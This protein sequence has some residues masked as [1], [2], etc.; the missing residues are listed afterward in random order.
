MAGLAQLVLLPFDFLPF[1]RSLV[2]IPMLVFLARSGI[3]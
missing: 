3:R 1:P 2:R